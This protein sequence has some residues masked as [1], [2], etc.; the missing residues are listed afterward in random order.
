MSFPTSL[1]LIC[2]SEVA[3]WEF[4]DRMTLIK[5]RNRADPVISSA[6]AKMQQEVGRSMLVLHVQHTPENTPAE[7]P[8]R[9]F[10]F[11]VA[12]ICSQLCDTQSRPTKFL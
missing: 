1:F 3:F 7:I 4:Y 5:S 2:L 9:I 10:D 6:A 11:A 8:K 12:E